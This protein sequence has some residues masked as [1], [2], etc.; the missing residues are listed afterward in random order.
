MVISAAF[1][2]LIHQVIVLVLH[3]V[4]LFMESFETGPAQVDPADRTGNDTTSN[5]AIAIVHPSVQLA[6]RFVRCF[7]CSVEAA[8]MIKAHSE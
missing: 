7:I 5:N 3:Q 6:V 8:K 2:V 4:L 1:L